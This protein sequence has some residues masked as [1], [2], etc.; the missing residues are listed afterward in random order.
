MVTREELL[1]Q[2]EYWT[3]Q[4]QIMLYDQA[5]KFMERNNM[6]RSQLAEYLGVSKGYV[7]QLLSGDYN[8]RMSKFFEL[9]LAIGLVPIVDF[10]PIENVIENDAQGCIK[11]LAAIVPTYDANN[12][13]ELC[14][15]SRSWDNEQKTNELNTN[16]EMPNVG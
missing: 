11:Q 4:T 14:L 2:P 6:N 10:V 9:A 8:H 12:T 13:K 3:A 1:K 15:V 5:A 16:E 7:T